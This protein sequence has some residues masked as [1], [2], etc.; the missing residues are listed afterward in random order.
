MNTLAALM[1]L[2]ACHPQQTSCLDEPVA[3]I[4][5]AS[6]AECRAA[7][8]SE[9]DK[10]RRMAKLIYGDCVPVNAE[11]LAGREI[12]RTIDPVKLSA[13]TA[14]SKARVAVKA[15]SAAVMAPGAGPF[16]G[17]EEAK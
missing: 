9:M 12:R 4:S 8:P 11:L 5:Y 3:V 10:A 6:G 13:L 1:V 17:Y 7:L 16:G 15:F 14:P 2:V